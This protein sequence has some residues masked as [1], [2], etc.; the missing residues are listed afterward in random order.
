MISKA[1][2][3][4]TDWHE[5]QFRRT[6]KLPY[7]T[8]PIAV[9]TYVRSYC[10]NGYENLPNIIV[11]ALLHDVVEDCK[12]SVVDI[13][14]EFGEDVGNMVHQLTSDKNETERKGKTEYL[15]IK[16]GG[17]R[18]MTDDTLIVKLCDR[19]DNVRDYAREEPISQRAR[20][21]FASTQKI[22]GHVRQSRDLTTIHENIIREILQFCS[23]S[24]KE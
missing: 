7:I 10:P 18:N 4:A 5:G 15:K 24:G 16:M 8:H 12:V 11:A 1:L 14:R 21:Y 23:I 2:K 19:L 17:R 13:K 3:F 9:A 20:E 6:S 22:L